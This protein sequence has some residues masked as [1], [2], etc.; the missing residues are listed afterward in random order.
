MGP[1]LTPPSPDRL[2][3]PEASPETGLRSNK[4]KKRTR[5][6]DE[7]DTLGNTCLM[8]DVMRRYK[9]MAQAVK[10]KEVDYLRKKREY[11][12]SLDD[13]KLFEKIIQQSKNP[14]LDS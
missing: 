14:Q 10:E 13:L 7:R 4:T 8:D 3:R 9:K 1:T 11:L 12:Q 6:E 5:S 2:P